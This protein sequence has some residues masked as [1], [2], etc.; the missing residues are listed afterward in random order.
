MGVCRGNTCLRSLEDGSLARCSGT[1]C[2]L[3][4]N[5]SVERGLLLNLPLQVLDNDSSLLSKSIS[6]N[7][8]NECLD[9]NRLIRYRL[10]PMVCRMGG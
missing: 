8:E 3:F 2:P 4:Q 5:E 1:K 7:I 10:Q 9:Y 6:K